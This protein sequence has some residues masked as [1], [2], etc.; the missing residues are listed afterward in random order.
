VISNEGLIVVADLREPAQAAE[1]NIERSLLRALSFSRNGFV[2]DIKRGRNRENLRLE[3]FLAEI[4][5]S[6]ASCRQAC[7]HT[8]RK[9]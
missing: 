2:L 6:I 8:T 9:R 3:Y 5:P 4:S 1:M 7:V